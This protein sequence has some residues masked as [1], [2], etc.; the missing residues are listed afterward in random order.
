MAKEVLIPSS[1]NTSIFAL[2]WGQRE[3]EEGGRGEGGGGEG[4]EEEQ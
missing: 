3:E 2:S 1:G 4:G